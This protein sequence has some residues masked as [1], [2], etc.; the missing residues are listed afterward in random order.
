MKILSLSLA[1]FTLVALSH[2]AMAESAADYRRLEADAVRQMQAANDP[3]DRAEW[4][5]KA[6]FYR[7]QATRMALE[8]RGVEQGFA[9]QQPWKPTAPASGPKTQIQMQGANSPRVR[10]TP[11]NA[12]VILA[13]E[14]PKCPP[15]TVVY[16][17]SCKRRSDICDTP[18]GRGLIINGTCQVGARP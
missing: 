4:R 15:G 13:Q 6:E 18:Q 12:D 7:D 9:P 8:A 5:H 16:G 10:Q 2:S 17:D 3:S 1:A 14:P 11:G